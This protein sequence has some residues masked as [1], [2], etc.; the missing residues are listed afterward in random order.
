M[1]WIANPWPRSNLRRFESCSFRLWRVSSK[2]TSGLENRRHGNTWAFDSSTR[3]HKKGE[4]KTLYEY[5]KENIAKGV[6]DFS[7]RA[8]YNRDGEI[9]LYIHPDSKDGETLDFLV[10]GN[11]LIPK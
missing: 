3:R 10:L 11:E 9:E 1:C 5:L 7:I 8:G 4:M 6:I 2:G